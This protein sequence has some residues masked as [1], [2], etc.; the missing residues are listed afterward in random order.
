MGANISIKVPEGKDPNEVASK[1]REVLAQSG[2]KNITF[3]VKKAPSY[4]AQSGYNMESLLADTMLT[5]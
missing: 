1:V 3:N 5:R 4:S 2:Y